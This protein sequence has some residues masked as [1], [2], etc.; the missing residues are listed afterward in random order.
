MSGPS[1]Q[2]SYLT[3]GPVRRTI[4]D[5][6]QHREERENQHGRADESADQHVAERLPERV[7]Q[8]ERKQTVAGAVAP[9]LVGGIGVG[10]TPTPIAA[11]DSESPEAAK[12][13]KDVWR[14][15]ASSVSGLMASVS[16]PSDVASVTSSSSHRLAATMAA[17]SSSSAAM[18]PGGQQQ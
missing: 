11:V 12:R 15:S 9:F 5:Q 1:H 13:V 4:D 16:R 18:A 6:I 10:I 14:T 8:R 2:T 7:A 17:C 3:A